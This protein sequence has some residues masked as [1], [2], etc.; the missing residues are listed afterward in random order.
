VLVAAM[1]KVQMLSSRAE[2]MYIVI[3]IL[4][5]VKNVEGNNREKSEPFEFNLLLQDVI[6][7]T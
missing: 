1:L 6:W 7:L 2:G 4:Y 3:F 5:R